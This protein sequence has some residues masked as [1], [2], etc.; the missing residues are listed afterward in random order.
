MMRDGNH[1]HNLYDIKILSR[2]HLAP[3]SEPF[4]QPKDAPFAT[5]DVLRTVPARVFRR[6]PEGVALLVETVGVVRCGG[7]VSH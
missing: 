3:A 2:G 7:T 6:L 1:T 4:P 5:R